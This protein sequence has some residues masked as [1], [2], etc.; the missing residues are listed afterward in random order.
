MRQVI[1]GE[2][3]IFIVLAWREIFEGD[4]THKRENLGVMNLPKSLNYVVA[5]QL[6]AGLIG[7]D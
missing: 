1:K 6:V 7:R 2:E 5:L 3:D 4:G